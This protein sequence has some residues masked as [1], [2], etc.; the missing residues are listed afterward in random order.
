MGTNVRWRITAAAL[1]LLLV[2]G[3]CDLGG[4]S[5][6]AITSGTAATATAGSGSATATATTIAATSTPT[7]TPCSTI[8][9]GYG[10][11]SGGALF[12][13][14]S[15]PSLSSSTSV[16]LT[17]AGNVYTFAIYGE[18]VC[19]ANSSADAVRAFFATKLPATGFAQSNTF[20]F[21]G[22]FAQACGDP[23]CWA[24]P[25]ARYVGLEN[26]Q[27]RGNSLVTY[28]LRFAFPPAAPTCPGSG[29]SAGYY[30]KLP[31]IATYTDVE[32]APITRIRAAV[33][34]GPTAKASYDLCAPFYMDG[35]DLITFMHAHGG[36]DPVSPGLNFVGPQG[37][38]IVSGFSGT[39][40]YTSFY[41]E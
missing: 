30:T 34:P 17:H 7:I 20:P 32:L 26:V 40:P 27:D 2:L 33:G 23:Y 19:T 15:F 4:S 18:D 10:S 13:D 31:A 5:T 8:V 11:A 14:V 12:N 6:S 22:L 37:T 28:H 35:G 21:D 29:W 3:A 39:P 25:H 9:S 16:T 1:G 38:I 36:W 24:S 41:L